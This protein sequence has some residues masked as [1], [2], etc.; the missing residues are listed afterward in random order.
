M[1]ADGPKLI[2][3]GN[4]RNILECKIGKCNSCGTKDKRNNRNIL[5]CKS[6]RYI[7]IEY[8][9]TTEIIETYWNVKILQESG[10]DYPGGEIIE[11]YWNVKRVSVI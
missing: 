11:T 8:S 6:V 1:I 4:N 10:G 3:P 2:F 9:R 5:E 7:I